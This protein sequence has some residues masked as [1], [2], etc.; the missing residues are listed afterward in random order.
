MRDSMPTDV[1][2]CLGA[3]DPLLGGH[4]GID[5]RQFHVV[6]RRGSRQQVEGLEYEADFLVADAGQFVVIQ[7]ADQLAVQP[8]VAPCWAYPGSR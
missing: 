1:S 7:F 8:I 6:Q 2:A 3:L 4:A 5:Q